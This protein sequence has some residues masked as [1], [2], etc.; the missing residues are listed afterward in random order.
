MKKS[1]YI[2]MMETVLSAYSNEHIDRY[3]DEVKS[4]GIKEHGFPRLTA[5]IGILIAHGKRCD[6]LPRFLK[7][8]DLCCNGMPGHTDIANDFSV[9]EIIF[10]LLELEK[11][12]TLPQAQLDRWKNKLKEITVESSYTVY[13][14]APDSKVYNWAAFT[15]LSEWMRY[16]IKVAPEDM[17]FIDLQAASQLQWLDENGMYRDPN[18]PMVYDLVTRG[19]FALLLHLGYRGKYFEVWDHA[20]KQAGLLTLK[21]VSVTGEI[22]YGGRSNQFLHNEAH[23]ALLMEYEAARYAGSNDMETAARCKGV[24]RRAL[25]HMAHWLEQHPINHV[26]NAFPRSTGYGCEKYAYFDKYMITTASFLY[27]AYLLCD[28][29]IPCAEPDDLSG[30]SW[31]S[32]AAFH[33]VFL[34]AGEYFA[35]YDYLANYHYDASGLGR[36][37]RKGVPGAICISTPG[38]DSPW[39]SI[40]GA[41]ATPFAIVPAIYH[42]GEWFSG[43][44]PAVTHTVEEHGAQGETAFLRTCCI[45]EGKGIVKTSYS[46]DQNGL[47]IIVEGQGKVGLIIPAFDFDGREKTEISHSGGTLSIHYQGHVCSWRS[48]QGMICDTGSTGYNRNGYYKL[49]RAE[50]VDRLVVRVA[51]S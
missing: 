6:L 11:H 46:L 3:Y 15:M 13:A 28:D 24:V 23:C 20:L 47:L 9:K 30:E 5:D 37:H 10:S 16:Q 51:I 7:M 44:E 40:N 41:T 8:M 43:A 50:A 35:E 26:K 19:L 21:M 27:V 12:H 36:L 14:T 33:K 31:Q 29:S 18:E 4:G 48:E 1:R 42:E 25:D 49:F 39:Y 45:W 17:E 2:D 22:P 32:S 34:R 38:T